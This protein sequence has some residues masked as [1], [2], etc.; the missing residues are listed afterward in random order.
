MKKI[1]VLLILVLSV[2]AAWGVSGFDTTLIPEP[3][4]LREGFILRGVD[5]RLSGP[6]GNGAW[7]F[8]LAEYVNDFRDVLA[9]GTKVQVLPSST[10]ERMIADGR[11]RSEMTFRLW[12]GRI[13][14]YKGR[15]YIFP[16]FFLPVSLG[17]EPEQEVL[18]TPQ[19]A[20]PDEIIETPPWQEGEPP[21]ITRDPND[22]IT[23]P[24][25]ILEKLRTTRETMAARKR[26]IVDVNDSPAAEPNLPDDGRKRSY[27]GGSDSVFVNRTGFI[28][29]RD[30]GSFI[31]E[32]DALG[33]NV[34]R[35]SLRLLPCEALELAEM[36][37][38]AVFEPV[39]FR[40][41]GILTEYE[42]VDYLLLHKATPAY[43]HGNFGR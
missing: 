2:G 4:L 43:S 14:R 18:E 7:F 16:S 24:S 5:G 10:L 20:R 23:I 40:A 32:L 9:A 41:A 13:T 30:D 17:K 11:S 12:N 3:P 1:P 19:T 22:I 8:E 15:N 33:R 21:P 31:F 28:V 39:R 25:D 35:R 27:A 6:D 42:N 29:G 36:K 37:I 38:S 26:Q 34:R